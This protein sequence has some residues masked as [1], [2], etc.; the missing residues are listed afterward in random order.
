MNFFL[1][2]LPVSVSTSS[3]LGYC[4]DV[5]R[6]MHRVFVVSSGH[7]TS[8]YPSGIHSYSFVGV[9][10]LT[11]CGSKIFNPLQA[12]FLAIIPLAKV[13]TGSVL[14]PY[15]LSLIML[16]FTL[17]LLSFATEQLSLGVGETWAGFVSAS[18]VRDSFRLKLSFPSIS[19]AFAG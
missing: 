11:P 2:A 4:V 19:L 18:M 6:M 13:C 7:C 17:K 8:P 14:L 3:N 5:T 1:F 10:H 12:S 15:T 16:T 9:R